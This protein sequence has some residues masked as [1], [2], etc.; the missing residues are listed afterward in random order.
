MVRRLLARLPPEI[1]S[2]ICPVVSVHV[3]NDE[4][5]RARR[6]AGHASHKLIA[7]VTHCCARPARRAT[8]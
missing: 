7:C 6:R 2:S 8:C 4:V 1:H 5:R 3:Y